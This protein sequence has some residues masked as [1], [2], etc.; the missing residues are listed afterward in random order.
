MGMLIDIKIN[1][2]TLHHILVRNVGESDFDCHKYEW[3]VRNH[4]DL[5]G[6]V[7][8]RRKNGALALAR[9]VV[10]TVRMAMDAADAVETEE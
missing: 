9:D 4:V 8:H 10:E 2:E 7:E 6:F 5:H 1:D 3:Q